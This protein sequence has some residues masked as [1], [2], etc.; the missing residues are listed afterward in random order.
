MR[1]TQFEGV[2][3]P[4]SVYA[5]LKRLGLKS[6]LVETGG[7]IVGYLEK[8]DVL[9]LHD[10]VGPGPR[11]EQEYGSVLVDGLAATRFCQT[12]KERTKG[13]IDYVGDWHTHVSFSI[14]PSK[15][16]LYAMQEMSNY[17]TWS[18]YP[19]ISVILSTITACHG[20]Y[21][22]SNDKLMLVPSLVQ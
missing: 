18:G 7:P 1:K 12:W 10:A 22:L 6:R 8:D 3:I 16:D 4:R 5:K 9:V 17:T 14:K 19:P 20:V 11:G 13:K 21:V 15:R 2:I